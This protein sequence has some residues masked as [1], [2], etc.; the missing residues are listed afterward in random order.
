MSHVNIKKSNSLEDL[1]GSL[2]DLFGEDIWIAKS[3]I[4]KSGNIYMTFVLKQP[5]I[6]TET[7]INA[8]RSRTS[9]RQESIQPPNLDEHFKRE[10]NLNSLGVSAAEGEEA[11]KARST[12]KKPKTKK[13]K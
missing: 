7:F 3:G 9:M 1:K 10:K 2:K 8:L 5:L 13:K 11:P 4:S 6:N 12:R